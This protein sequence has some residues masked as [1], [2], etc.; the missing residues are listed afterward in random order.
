MPVSAFDTN[1]FAYAAGIG[2]T[3][4]DK[5]KVALAG[6]LLAQVMVSEPLV[7]P[8]QVCLEFHHL[9]IRKKRLPPIEAAALLREY[10]DGALIV[11]SDFAVLENA[12]DLAQ[13]HQLQTYDAVILA[14]AAHA[15]CELLFSEDMQHGFEWEG[16]RI[17]N[18]FA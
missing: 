15:G 4:A 6:A 11:P 5:P 9:L 14:A 10:T 18:P 8:V 13:T 17:V 16:V 7:V 2:E 12:F 3:L 1:I